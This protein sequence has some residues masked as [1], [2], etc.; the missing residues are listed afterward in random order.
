LLKSFNQVMILAMVALLLASCG[1][2]HTPTGPV[3][4]GALSV[5]G[6]SWTG[7]VETGSVRIYTLSSI[8]AGNQYLVRTVIA[9]GGKL[10][11]AVYTSFFAYK[12]GDS[13]VATAQETAPNYYEAFIP[14]TVSGEYVIVLIGTPSASSDSVLN[15]YD[16]RL[17]SASGSVLTSFITPTLSSAFTV[18]GLAREDQFSAVSGT[19]ISSSSPSSYTVLLTSSTL[20][21]SHPQMFIYRDNSLSLAS[22]LYSAIAT[23]DL[24]THTREFL[25]SDFTSNPTLSTFASNSYFSTECSISNV[26]F[27]TGTWDGPFIMVRGVS[28][29]TYTLSVVP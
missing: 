27:P 1:N 8:K 23:T 29:A 4:F 24:Q 25:I 5:N 22:L 20:T 11:A 13:P 10:H 2:S 12:A 28:R 14:A 9:P 6:I 26:S 16:L 7:N 21:I 19:F 3:P 17:M 18:T 15:F